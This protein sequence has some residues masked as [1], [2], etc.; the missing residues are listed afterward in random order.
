MARIIYILMTLTATVSRADIRFA[1]VIAGRLPDVALV[2]NILPLSP[3]DLAKVSVHQLQKM[4][5]E[6]LDQIYAR[7]GSGPIP[8]GD[9]RSSILN[10]NTL[11][12]KLE[13]KAIAS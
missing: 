3:S 10:K 5:Q 2:E 12:I 9:Y 8:K 4:N 11:A 7:L 6:Q 1:P 13:D